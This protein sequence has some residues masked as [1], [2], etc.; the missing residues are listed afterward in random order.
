MKRKRGRPGYEARVLLPDESVEVNTENSTSDT[1]IHKCKLPLQELSINKPTNIQVSRDSCKTEELSGVTK[2]SWDNL[3]KLLQPV[4]PK[5]YTYVVEHL[6]T[7]QSRGFVGAQTY[8]FRAQFRMSVTH[9]DGAQSWLTSMMEHSQCTY[10]VTRT[11]KPEMKRVLYRVDMHCQHKQKQLS[12]K[13]LASKSSRTSQKG[14][15]SELRKKKTNCLSTLIMTIENPVRKP[16]RQCHKQSTVYIQLLW[17]YCLTITT[18]YIVLTVLA[19]APLHNIPKI[20][21][22][23]CFALD[24]LQ[25]QHGTLT[26]PNCF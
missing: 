19:F 24:I 26:N 1:T 18:P 10:R 2:Y 22:L 20:S 7:L 6:E 3:P 16:I 14:L 9:A 8:P 21:S 5:G 11:Y 15:A 25:Q 17:S 23:S 4:L 12:L 13:Q